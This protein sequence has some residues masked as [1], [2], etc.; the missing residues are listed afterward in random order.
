MT[1]LDVH[2][3]LGGTTEV[4][5]DTINVATAGDN[6]ILAA[7]P[8]TKRIVV[9]HYLLN[10]QGA[11]NLYWRDGA[12]GAAL[13][14]TLAFGAAGFLEV[15]YRDGVLGTS[16]GTALVL[17]LSAVVQVSGHIAYLLV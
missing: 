2:P 12:G 9:V 13:C 4:L 7:P 15:S 8:A 16:D 1:Y 11:V 14:G 6:E 10:P 3:S 17:N 5:F